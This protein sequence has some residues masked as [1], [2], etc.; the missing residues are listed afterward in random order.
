[1]KFK[2]VKLFFY[3]LHWIGFFYVMEFALSKVNYMRL[4]RSLNFCLKKG[5]GRSFF[6]LNIMPKND[7]NGKLVLLVGSMRYNFHYSFYYLRNKVIVVDKDLNAKKY[8]GRAEFIHD[9]VRN[10]K[11]YIDDKSISLVQFNGIYGWG[12]NSIS[13]LNQAISSVYEVMNSNSTLLFGFNPKSHDKERLLEKIHYVFHSFEE[14]QKSDMYF[15]LEDQIYF[16][17]KKI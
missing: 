6:E 7:V 13:A 2:L 10:I 14:I 16:N 5:K 15:V 3:I 11:S 9:D 12:I 17:A 8:I 4:L 1:M